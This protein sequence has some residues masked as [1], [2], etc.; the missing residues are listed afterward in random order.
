MLD[1]LLNNFG[2]LEK[3]V[4]HL[5]MIFFNYNYNMLKEDRWTASQVGCGEFSKSAIKSFISITC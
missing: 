4:Q 3:F 1:A 2:Q 5:P